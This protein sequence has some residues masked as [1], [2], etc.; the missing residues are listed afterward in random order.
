MQE[1]V[2]ALDPPLLLPV[3]AET[4]NSGQRGEWVWE[5]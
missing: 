3:L 2:A 1:A 5:V 4:E